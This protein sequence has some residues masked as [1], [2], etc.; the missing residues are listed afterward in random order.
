MWEPLNLADVHIILMNTFG[1]LKALQKSN[2]LKC[3]NLFLD[4]KV[5]HTLLDDSPKYKLMRR[6][7]FLNCKNYYNE[8]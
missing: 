5:S 7:L 6:Q 8:I 2:K 4:S 3:K 1:E